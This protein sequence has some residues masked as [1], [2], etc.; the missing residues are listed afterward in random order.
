MK[1]DAHAKFILSTNIA[2]HATSIGDSASDDCNAQK[3]FGGFL[4]AIAHPVCKATEEL[5]KNS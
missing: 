4:M 1:S 2:K 5:Y 3:L